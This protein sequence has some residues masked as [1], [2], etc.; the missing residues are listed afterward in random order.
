LL[1]IVAYKYKKVLDYPLYNS[2]KFL[3]AVLQ[4]SRQAFVVFIKP[5]NF[6]SIEALVVKK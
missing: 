5:I 2:M 3:F 1:P 4:K 6:V